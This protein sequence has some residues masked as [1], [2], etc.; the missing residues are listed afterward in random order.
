MLTN[1]PVRLQSDSTRPRTAGVEQFHPVWETITPARA[2]EMLKRCYNVR[3]VDREHVAIMSRAMKNGTWTPNGATV[4]IDEDGYVVD[5]EHRLRACVNAGVAFG[6][7][8]V[9]GFPRRNI[10]AVDSGQRRRTAAQIVR[11]SGTKEAHGVSTLVKALILLRRGLPAARL[12]KERFTDISEMVLCI[13]QDKDNLERAVSAVRPALR[14]TRMPCLSLA[15]IA[16]R[17]AT[18]PKLTPFL[19][20]LE[21]GEGGRKGDPAFALRER[22]LS[23]YDSVRLDTPM[24]CALAWKAWNLTVKGLSVSVLRLGQNQEVELPLED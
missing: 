13:E 2:E 18:S 7:L 17:A 1:M 8:V 14:V 19:A 4:L 11:A 3:R 5:G 22:V 10:M 12:M 20:Y 9:Y 6:T 24:S 15:L 16:Y 21:T 23:G